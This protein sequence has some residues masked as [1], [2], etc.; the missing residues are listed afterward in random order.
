MLGIVCGSLGPLYRQ[1][2]ERDECALGNRRV[3]TLRKRPEKKERRKR[4]E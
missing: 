3:E 1:P 2:K 4:L